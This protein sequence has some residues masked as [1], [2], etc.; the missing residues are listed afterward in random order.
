MNDDQEKSNEQPNEGAC[1][2]EM[3]VRPPC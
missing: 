1:L 3:G 2:L